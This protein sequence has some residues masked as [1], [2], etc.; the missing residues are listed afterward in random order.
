MSVATDELTVV[1][2]PCT[3]VMLAANEELFVVTV[4]FRVVTRPANDDEAVLRVLFVETMDAEL[5]FTAL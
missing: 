1:T 2:V 5:S 3:L 4:E